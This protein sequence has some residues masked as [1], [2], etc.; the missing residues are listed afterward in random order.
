MK[1]LLCFI[2]AAVKFYE[3]DYPNRSIE[4]YASFIYKLFFTLI[5][6]HKLAHHNKD[7]LIRHILPIRNRRKKSLSSGSFGH[8]RII[9]NGFVWLCICKIWT[10][11]LKCHILRIRSLLFLALWL[12]NISPRTILFSFRNPNALLMMLTWTIAADGNCN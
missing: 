12:L 5:S 7:I 9:Q 1:R 11:L 4:K 10:K 2:E 8:F 6:K 3:Q